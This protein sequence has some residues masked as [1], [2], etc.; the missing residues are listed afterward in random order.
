MKG[1]VLHRNVP[2]CNMLTLPKTTYTKLHRRQKKPQMIRELFGL[3]LGKL[4]D[5]VLHTLILGLFHCAV[6]T[7][8]VTDHIVSRKDEPE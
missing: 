6:S 5:F 7:T 3:C 8:D 2:D 4:M 1:N